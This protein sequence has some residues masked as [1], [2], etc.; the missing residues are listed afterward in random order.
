MTGTVT[1]PSSSSVAD[2]VSRLRELL[3][4]K[5]MEVFGV[6]DQAAEARQVGLQLR[7]TV[8][9]LFGSP[10]AGTPVMV[11]SPLAALDLP[12]KILIWD[13]DGHTKITYTAPGT[14]AA[15]YALPPELAHNLA[16]IDALADAL[17]AGLT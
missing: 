2:T 15:R 9:V 14:L 7:D 17:A 8:L 6:I 13:D 16:G 1:R 4:A 12:L 5:G 3:A 10:L 11:A